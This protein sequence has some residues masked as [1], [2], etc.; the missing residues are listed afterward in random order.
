MI[1][2]A[3]DA[4]GAI[5]RTLAGDTLI[6]TPRGHL[7]L[8]AFA[9]H[10]VPTLVLEST[11][12]AA[13]GGCCRIAVDAYV[14]GALNAST[15]AD[16]VAS[17]L[18]PDPVFFP[19]F[20]WE[21]EPGLTRPYSRKWATVL[22]AHQS[23]G[24]P[25]LA[26]VPRTAWDGSSRDVQ[27]LVRRV[28]HAVW[29]EEDLDRRSIPAG[30]TTPVSSSY[31]TANGRTVR[32][33][34]ADGTTGRKS[35]CT[36]LG[37]LVP[38]TGM[39]APM[40]QPPAPP[41]TVTKPSHRRD[42]PIRHSRALLGDLS[43]QLGSGLRDGKSGRAQREALRVLIAPPLP[44]LAGTALVEDDTSGRARALD[45]WVTVTVAR[46][47][48]QPGARIVVPSC[49]SLGVADA[50]DVVHRHVPATDLAKA[51]RR[52]L[53]RPAPLP[54]HGQPAPLHAEATEG[55]AAAGAAA[56]VLP[57]RR[58]DSVR[59]ATVTDLVAAAQAAPPMRLE[60]TPEL[61]VPPCKV[62]EP[63]GLA[64]ALP[65]VL[66]NT[67]LV[68]RTLVVATAP[69]ASVTGC[70]LD[71]D[72]CGINIRYCPARLRG[73]VRDPKRGGADPTCGSR[74]TPR[75]TRAAPIVFCAPLCVRQSVRSG[76]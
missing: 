18:A 33:F 71:F 13:L 28:Q 25:L 27:L 36:L 61:I 55:G 52:F 56:H 48:Q 74:S 51:F 42:T 58:L 12:A 31:V 35:L 66:H 22:V 24:A 10:Q 15:R 14:R 68:P 69:A 60:D 45:D 64:A 32:L 53:Q 7:A 40:W 57:P 62:F 72:G 11:Q 30:L 41:R 73:P 29:N 70:S 21:S 5:L 16:L 49:A 76:R 39:A 37:R 8:R 4:S 59:G 26:N 9:I 17:D 3:R 19:L 2:Q 44:T 34:I 63:G 67:A 75:T 54:A 65:H 20:T 1:Q 23:G 6:E 43:D 47:A 38:W 50:G 46:L